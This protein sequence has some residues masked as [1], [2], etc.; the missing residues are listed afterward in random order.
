[1]KSFLSFAFPIS[2]LPVMVMAELKTSP[3]DFEEDCREVTGFLEA[4]GY[5]VAKCG[6]DILAMLRPEHIL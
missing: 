3:G 5:I 6:Q 1:M 4:R 2:E